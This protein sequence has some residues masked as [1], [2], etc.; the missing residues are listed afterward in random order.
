MGRS[1]TRGGGR[2]TRGTAAA[3]PALIHQRNK[4]GGRPGLFLP[5]GAG[6]PIMFCAGGWGR[7]SQSHVLAL[8][9]DERA[10]A[11]GQQGDVERLLEGV[12]VAVLGK[13]LGV[14]LVLA[15]QG[16]DQRVLVRLVAPQVGGD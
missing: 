3:T 1:C 15:G 6:G 7:P 5:P 14:G 8:L 11:L 9:L 16:D 13:A 2:G 12:A 10:D 4:E